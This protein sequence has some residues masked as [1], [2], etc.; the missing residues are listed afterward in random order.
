MNDNLIITVT[1]NNFYSVYSDGVFERKH[2]D[3]DAEI[4][5]LEYGEK[6]VILLYY[7][8]PVHRRV[9]LVRNIS[10]ETNLTGLPSLSKK[11][12]IIFKN[13]ASRVDKTRRVF[14]HIREHYGSPFIF[15]D[16]FYL[17]LDFLIK[18]KGKI[19]YYLIDALV[20]KYILKTQSLPESP[21]Q[22]EMFQMYR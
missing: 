1:P 4:T 18:Q 20:E 9:Y 6:A 10:D 2:F 14:G 16:D 11:V 17:R 12:K 8:Y 22:P 7:T 15:P 19:K 21:K 5:I 3:K 13:T